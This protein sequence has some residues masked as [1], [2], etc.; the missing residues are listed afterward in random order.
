MSTESELVRRRNEVEILSTE[1]D[2]L[3]LHI[4]RLESEVKNL[5]L[6]EQELKHK[7][8]KRE[9]DCQKK[10][11]ELE[12]ERRRDTDRLKSEVD[13]VRDQLNETSKPHTAV[14]FTRR[15]GTLTQ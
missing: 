14:P 12:Q 9:E 15:H 6:S 5:R 13:T 10:L 1:E 11:C 4:S 8:S 7:L 3:K 2:T